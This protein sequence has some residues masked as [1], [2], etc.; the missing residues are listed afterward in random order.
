M[1][2]ISQRF[3]YLIPYLFLSGHPLHTEKKHFYTV[4]QYFISSK[5]VFL[6]ST[7]F[8]IFTVFF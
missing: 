5:L 6:Y 7:L 3:T 4:S 8:V 2:Y 1:R